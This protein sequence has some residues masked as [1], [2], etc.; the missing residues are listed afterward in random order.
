MNCDQVPLFGFSRGELKPA[1]AGRMAVHVAGCNTCAQRLQVIVALQEYYR[2]RELGWRR[3]RWLL[4][5]AVLALAVAT[6]AVEQVLLQD[7]PPDP[8]VLAVSLPTI[9]PVAI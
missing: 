4:V 5:A 3:P 6:V 7:A 9:L 8:S 1:S 2:K